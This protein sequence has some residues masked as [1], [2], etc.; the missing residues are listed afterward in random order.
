MSYGQQT[1]PLINHGPKPAEHITLSTDIAGHAHDYMQIVIG[2]KGSVEFDVS[3]YG[4]RIAPGQGCVVS[5]SST[6]VF[7]GIDKPSDIFVVNLELE[8][9]VT[10]SAIDQVYRLTESDCYFGL[11]SQ[12]VKLISLLAEEVQLDPDD[13]L[14]SQACSNTVIALLT[15]HTRPFQTHANF[16][17]LNMDVIDNYIDRH[18]QRRIS[19][20]ELA[21]S[22]FLSESHF[23]NQFKKQTGMT[24][25]Q[26]LLIKRIN[27][28]KYLIETSDYS[29]NYVSDITG[30][31]GQSAFTRSF[32]KYE[33]ISPSQYKKRWC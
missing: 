2:L 1:L 8:H 24:P 13:S 32:T 16:G 27:H 33:G 15:R 26:Y 10:S 23:F 14:L 3:G 7:G 12:T 4:N 6:H 17:R 25:H 18:I 29:L 11:T 22:V 5:P 19:V 30:F 21:G 9:P 31:S 28:A 20:C